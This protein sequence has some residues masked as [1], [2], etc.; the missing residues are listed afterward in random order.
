MRRVFFVGLIQAAL[1]AALVVVAGPA[2]PA[3]AQENP[4]ET[5]IDVRMGERVFRAQCG[6][7]HGRDGRGNDETGAPDLT[8]GQFSRV[9]SDAGMFDVIRDGIDGTAMIG[10]SPRASDQSVW[11]IVSYINSLNLDPADYDLPG[12][13]GRGE[14][15]YAGAACSTCHMVRGQ[16]GRT[17]PDLSTVGSRLDPDEIATSLSDPDAEVAP[18]WWTMR[19]NRADGSTIEGLRMNEDTFTVRIMDNDENLWSFMKSEVRSLEQIKTS[20]M[21]AAEGLNASEMD[22]L[23]AYLFSLRRES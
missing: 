6:R 23:V 14:Q 20:T 5:L 11:Q 9:S 8:T 15:V 22:D 4:Y 1:V 2:A 21:P 16:G 13:A 12:D 7:C 17:G 18:R 3:E 10:I 19:I